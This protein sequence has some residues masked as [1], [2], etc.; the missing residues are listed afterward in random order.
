MSH[1]DPE[2]WHANSFC[3]AHTEPLRAHKHHEKTHR[4]AHAENASVP[5][6]WYSC[7]MAKAITH[8]QLYSA[9]SRLSPVSSPPNSTPTFF[10]FLSRH[11][12]RQS[13]GVP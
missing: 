3:S 8:Q 5:I 10:H 2:L 13:T 6:G 9:L 1:N 7:P 12:A 4:V 11:S